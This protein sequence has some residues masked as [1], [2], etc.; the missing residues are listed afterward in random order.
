MSEENNVIKS[1]SMHK[2]P[3]CDKEFYAESQMIPPVVGTLFTEEDVKKAKEDCLS[4]LETISLEDDQREA[5]KNWINSPDT[6]FGPT[7]VEAIILSLLKSE[8]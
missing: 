2:C 8:E 3:H 6:I 5:V 4:R 7:E 1:I